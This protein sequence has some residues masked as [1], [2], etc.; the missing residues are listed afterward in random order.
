ME[1]HDVIDTVQELGAE[2]LL[3]LVVN[4]R[5]HAL[6]LGVRIVLASAGKAQAHRLRD[7]LG[8]QVRGEDEDGVLEVDDATLAIGK[9]AVFQHLQQGVVDLFVGLFDLI[10]KHHGER[11]AANL[12]GQLAALFVANVSRRSTEEAGSGEAV[13]ELTHIDLDEVIIR[14][15]EE[16]SQRLRQLSLTHTGRAGEDEGTGRTA[17]IL[18]A[19]T[20]A[21]DGA[22]DGLDRLVLAN[23]ALVQLLFHVEQAGRFLLRQLQHGDAGPVRQDLSDL[24]LAHLGDFLQVTGAPLLFLLGALLAQLALVIAQAGGLFE[25]LGIDSR[26]LF[27]ANLGNAVIDLAQ[28]LRGGHALDAH[29]GTGLIE[30][31]DGLVRQEAVIDVAVRQLRGGVQR[32][33][34]V[35]HAVVRL[36][37]IAQALQDE[38]GVIQRRFIDLHRLE[39]T[40]QRG[41][42]FDVLAVLIQGGSTDCLQLAAG[43]LG[44]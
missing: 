3:Q 21:A 18:Q 17:W 22:G 34:G 31:V 33:I 30:E 1:D 14:T 9:P 2:V 6:V 26:F 4:L 7:V 27:P 35:G 41:I 16:V 38:E 24:V 12:L 29:A 40:L 23:D 20:G 42:L 44:F 8:T 19:C 25:V 10:K 13:V 5:L 32:L 11:L 43:Q 37:L 39:T 15:E 28:A 36:V